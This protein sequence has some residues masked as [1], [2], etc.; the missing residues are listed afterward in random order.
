MSRPEEIVLEY[1]LL[2][3]HH[4]NQLIKGEVDHMYE[5]EDFAREMH[6]H[7][8]HLSNTIKDVAG[9]SPCGLYQPAILAIAKKLLDDRTLSIHEIGLK[10]DFDPSQFT[11]WFKRFTGITPKQYRA[12]SEIKTIL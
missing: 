10:L 1:R 5:I 3:D 11:R 7:P 8:A 6:I 9:T 2:I 4:L 12:N